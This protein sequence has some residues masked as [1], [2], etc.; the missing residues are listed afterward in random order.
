MIRIIVFLAVAS[1]LLI[2]AKSTTLGGIVLTVAGT[3]LLFYIGTS[4][5]D[6]LVRNSDDQ[7]A[8]LRKYTY[9]GPLYDRNASKKRYKFQR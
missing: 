7:Q 8:V 6:A 9:T 3:I 2:I 4:I 1:M 5:Q